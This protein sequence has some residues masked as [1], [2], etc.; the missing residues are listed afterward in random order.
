MFTLKN[1]KTQFTQNAKIAFWS[2]FSYVFIPRDTTQCTN[3]RP[4][5]LLSCFCINFW[6]NL[7]LVKC[8]YTLT[9]IIYSTSIITGFD[10]NTILP[11]ILFQTLRLHS[12]PRE[13]TPNQG[14]LFKTMKVYSKPSDFTP[15]PGSL[16]QT[17]RL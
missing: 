12:K 11:G 7:F 1:Y 17:L 2:F 8:F 3:Y 16:L 10:P 6:K 13:F 9:N 14:T 5:S 15:N 4:I